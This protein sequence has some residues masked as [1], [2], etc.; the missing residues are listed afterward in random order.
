MSPV[1]RE[2]GNEFKL[3]SKHLKIVRY[4]KWR[5][6]SHSFS[7]QNHSLENSKLGQDYDTHFR[8]SYNERLCAD[9]GV[10]G[11]SLIAYN[12]RLCGDCGVLGVSLI[13]YRLRRRIQ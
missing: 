11:V 5:L 7:N 1:Y 4:Q 10:L 13:A 3:C 9:C 6:C 12:D 8:V 2:L